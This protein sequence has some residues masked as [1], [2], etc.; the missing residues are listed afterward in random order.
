V[1]DKGRAK[2]TVE[3]LQTEAS[4]YLSRFEFQTENR[5]A[6][7]AA[8]KRGL[9]DQICKHMEAKY[10]DWSDKELQE[11]ALKYLN[12]NEFKKNSHSAY[13][14]A[15]KRKVLDQICQHMEFKYE[16]WTDEKLQEEALKYAN[17]VD[18]YRKNVAAYTAVKK[19]GLLDQICRHMAP[20]SNESF[21]ERSLIEYVQ[22][23]YPKTQKLRDRKV[24]IDNKPYIKGLD[25]DIYIPELRKGIEFDGDYWHS[26]QGLKRG[27]PD[28]PEEDLQNYHQIKDRYFL[29]K[30]I[31]ILHINQHEWVSNREECI[32]K[33]NIFLT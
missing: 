30:G 18:F 4:K 24:K 3:T 31:E 13:R 27:R 28:W 14:V 23:L 19:R 9:L 1:R 17:R 6:Y 22:S 5:K 12:R 15:I 33:I 25:I 32:K 26:N 11:E 10:R 29:S 16:H 2:W 8:H 21:D 7:Q 20:N